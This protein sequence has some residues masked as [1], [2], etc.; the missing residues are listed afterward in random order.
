M[1]KIIDAR[2]LDFQGLKKWFPDQASGSGFSVNLKLYEGDHWQ[3]GEMWSGEMPVDDENPKVKR[4]A[5][6]RLEK[7]HTSQNVVREIADRHRSGVVGLD[8]IMRYAPAVGSEQTTEGNTP[9]ADAGDSEADKAA[10]E[11]NRAVSRWA[12]RQG[13]RTKLQEVVKY[14]LLGDVEAGLRMWLPP[15][16]MAR[17]AGL[18]ADQIEALGTNADR[19]GAI[20]IPTG[21]DLA[22]ALD[23]IHLDVVAPGQGGL[24]TDTLTQDQFGVFFYEAAGVQYAEVS[25]LDVAL[26]PDGDRDPGAP[27]QTFIGTVRQDGARTD[28]AGFDLGGALTIKTVRRGGG[29]MITPQVRQLQSLLN[30]A[31]TG[32]NLNLDWAGFLERIFLNAQEPAKEIPDP[33]RPGETTVQPRPYKVGHGTAMFLAGHEIEDEDGNVKGVT[34]PSVVI[35]EPSEPSVYV[36]TADAARYAM[37]HEANQLHALIAGDAA[38]SGESRIQALADYII[39]LLLTSPAV[40]ELGL[41]LVETVLRFAYSLMGEAAPES[42][43]DDRLRAGFSVRIDPGPMSPEMVKAVIERVKAGLMSR[44]TALAMFGERDIDGELALIEQQAT[45][46]RVKVRAEVVKALTDAGMSLPS[47]LKE[48]GYSDDEIADMI[49]VGIPPEQ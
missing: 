44:P 27:T 13:L 49:A 22:S 20:P 4:E 47:A 2:T 1:F 26:T 24:Y 9:G 5:K 3:D 8:P 46:D 12:E 31:L 33:E 19:V 35:R 42:E 16:K 32:M 6:T 10:L 37:L 28:S 40:N 21:L 36:K 48:A 7:S 15:V 41:W 14:L 43:G 25:Y 18:S 30:K 17:A 11:A 23:L 34:N 39:S 29:A 38:P 45:L